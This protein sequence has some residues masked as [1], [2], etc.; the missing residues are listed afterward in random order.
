VAWIFTLPGSA[1]IAA[2]VYV[3][4]RFVGVN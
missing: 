2:V 1:L 4:L 3:L